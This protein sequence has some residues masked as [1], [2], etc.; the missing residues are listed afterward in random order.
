MSYVPFNENI[1]PLLN[2][3]KPYL[4]S[5]SK[6]VTDGILSLINVLGSHPGQEAIKAVSQVF[7]T[8][9]KNDRVITVN[10]VSGPVT[11]SLGLA[12]TLFL[13]LILL[14]LSG[15]LLAIG[16]GL[17]EAEQGVIEVEPTPEDSTAV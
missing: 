6:I 3:L 14:I 4:S 10:T 7:T 13:I 2:G 12:F 17:Q 15:N 9:G 8:S 5:K 11:F 16:C 1:V